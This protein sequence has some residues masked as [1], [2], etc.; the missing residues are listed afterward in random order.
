MQDVVK[1]IGT[2]S[3]LSVA[4]RCLRLQQQWTWRLH[5]STK[6]AGKKKVMKTITPDVEASDTNAC[7]KAKIEHME[8]GTALTPLMCSMTYLTRLTR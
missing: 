6:L 7:V 4:S 1:N 8:G 3:R 2:E 5:G